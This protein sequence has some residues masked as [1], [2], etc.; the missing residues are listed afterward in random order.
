MCIRDSVR[1][2]LWT[3]LGLWM[4]WPHVA[5]D[6]SL[7]PPLLASPL[8]LKDVA[9]SSKVQ[10]LTVLMGGAAYL[11]GILLEAGRRAQL[12]PDKT[13]KQLAGRLGAVFA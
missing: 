11:W 6:F 3:P 12:H 7:Q 5:E 2:L 10:V 8:R 4:A 1:M 13:D 9:N